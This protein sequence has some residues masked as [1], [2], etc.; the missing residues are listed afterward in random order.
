[1]ALKSLAFLYNGTMHYYSKLSFGLATYINYNTHFLQ[2]NNQLVINSTVFLT[3]NSL[4]H[5]KSHFTPDFSRAR[6]G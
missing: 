5:G 1:M 6:T 3:V 4:S 2:S